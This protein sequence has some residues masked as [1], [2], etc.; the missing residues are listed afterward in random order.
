MSDLK[1]VG[2]KIA[3]SRKSK[4]LSQKALAEKIGTAQCLIAEYES[5]ARSMTVV[6]L[7]EIS[8]VLGVDAAKL[9]ELE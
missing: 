1:S 5:G 4:G 8:K 7:L 2:A 3:L 9:L 6:R